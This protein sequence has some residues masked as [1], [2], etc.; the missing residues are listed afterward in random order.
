MLTRLFA[1]GVLLASTA[2][3]GQAFVRTQIDDTGVCI[4]WSERG[5]TFHLDS[6]GSARTP[7]DSELTAIEAAF[8]SWQTVSDLCSDFQFTE[9]DRV[10]APKVGY[11]AGAT[12]NQNV[13]TF[14]EQACED[15]VPAGDPCLSDDSCANAYRCWD[16]DTLVIAL[17]TTTFNVHT[18]VILDADMELNAAPQFDGPGFLFT[19][20]SSPPCTSSIS[21]DCVATDVQNTLTHEIGHMVG[22]AHSENP[23]ST[24]EATAPW[25]ETHKRVIDIG[26]AQGFCSIYPPGRPS[27]S[28]CDVTG[29]ASERIVASSAGTG[30]IGCA[31]TGGGAGLLSLLGAV[32][33]MARKRRA[34]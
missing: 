5:F 3:F 1:C 10:T 12:D 31:A 4:Y 7:G 20:V 18:G 2:A 26:T 28:A 32:L 30:P 15:V 11:T 33:W 17:T 19:T 22:L 9:G 23:G 21:T 27:N 6:A 34:A 29:Q 13:I 24:M 16:H 8:Q 25:G 14:R